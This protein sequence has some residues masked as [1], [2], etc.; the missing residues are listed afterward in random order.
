MKPTVA[1]LPFVDGSDRAKAHGVSAAFRD[2]TG[3][4]L[5][6]STAI[7]QV[8]RDNL[9]AALSEMELSLSGAAEGT[10][11][12]FGELLD[13]E[14]LLAGFV[15]EDS[16]AFTLTLKLVEVA[17]SAVS[18]A[19]SRELPQERVIADA[20]SYKSNVFQYGLGI[21][22][23]SSMLYWFANP[24]SDYEGQPIPEPLV[25]LSFIYRP[26]PWLVVGAGIDAT[27][28]QI[29]LSKDGTFNENATIPV[30]DLSPLTVDTSGWTVSEI[31]YSK[32]RT[33]GSGFLS[34]GFVFAPIQE[35][36]VTLGVSGLFTAGWVEQRYAE[37]PNVDGDRV[38]FTVIASCAETFD[39]MPWLKLQWFIAP[40]LA[41]N[42]TYEYRISLATLSS[43]TNGIIRY[44]IGPYEGTQFTQLHNLHPAYDPWGNPLLFDLTGHRISFG[45]GL[46]F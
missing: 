4:A 8:D 23:S 18:F 26:F 25:S 35:F 46:Y 40:R 9:D 3:V 28:T 39:V 15:G 44:T 41:L 45:I 30:A 24:M 2:A 21:E 43:A 36:N 37:F 27:A 29:R 31:Q 11:L 20:D 7:V 6:L 12:E 10:R 34:L 13:C 1:L 38:A 42:I 19:A 17:S 22:F 33:Y 16:G 5:Q 14:Y 32:Q